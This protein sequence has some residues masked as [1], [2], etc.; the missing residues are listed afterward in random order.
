MFQIPMKISTWAKVASWTKLATWAKLDT[1]A[2]RVTRAKLVTWAKKPTWPRMITWARMVT[3]AKTDY[4]SQAGYQD[5]HLSVPAAGEASQKRQKTKHQ[6]QKKHKLRWPLSEMFA[7]RRSSSD[8]RYQMVMIGRSLLYDHCQKII[9]I[10]SFPKTL[11]AMTIIRC[12]LSEMITTTRSLSDDH[13]W[14][15]IV[16]DEHYQV[17]ISYWS[18]S[19]KRCQVWSLSDNH[20]HMITFRWTFAIGHPTLN[21]RM[22]EPFLG[23]LSGPLP[24]S[25]ESLIGWLGGWLEEKAKDNAEKETTTKSAILRWVR[26]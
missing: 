15:I 4:V 22:H 13:Y 5:G 9:I 23:P 10:W 7:I 24:S 25:G 21:P 1:W 17:S 11:R 2:Q 6:N 26:C 14:V 20:S 18:F 19:D 12:P 8:K 3:G 16:R